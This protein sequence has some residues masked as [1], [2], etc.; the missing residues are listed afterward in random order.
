MLAQRIINLS[1]KHS[2]EAHRSQNE[3]LLNGLLCHTHYLDECFSMDCD[4]LVKRIVHE[5]NAC[6]T[7]CSIVKHVIYKIDGCSMDYD[8]LVKRIVHKT[9]ACSTDH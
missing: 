5:T 7:D 1:N 2:G 9:N 8:I 4:T 6:S 3:C